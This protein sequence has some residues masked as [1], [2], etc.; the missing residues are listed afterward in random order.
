MDTLYVIVDV[1]G[2]NTAAFWITMFLCVVFI[3]IA[4]LIKAIK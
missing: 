4:Q 2:T 1:P 3:T